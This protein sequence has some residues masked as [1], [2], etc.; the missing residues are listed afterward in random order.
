MI[1]GVLSF[2]PRYVLRG[3]IILQL[4]VTF[5]LKVKHL[6]CLRNTCP[7]RHWRLKFS[8]RIRLQRPQFCLF[9]IRLFHSTGRNQDSHLFLWNSAPPFL[10]IILLP[11]YFVKS[12]SYPPLVIFSFPPTLVKSGSTSFNEIQLPHPLPKWNPA[13]YPLK[14]QFLRSK[15]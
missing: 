8:C 15:R 12:G 5:S 11:L 4:S 1:E 6:K 2:L 14:S 10:G 9:G 13:P 3:S 7:K